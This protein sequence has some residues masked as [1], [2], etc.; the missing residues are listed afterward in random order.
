MPSV[1]WRGGAAI[2]G[3]HESYL[4]FLGHNLQLRLLECSDPTVEQASTLNKTACGRSQIPPSNQRQR[5]IG[6]HSEPQTIIVGQ[7]LNGLP[8]GLDLGD[9]DAP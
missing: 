4:P 7:A 1:T 3:A 8:I 5:L 2:T 6:R 9:V